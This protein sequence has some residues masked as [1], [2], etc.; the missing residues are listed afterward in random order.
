MIEIHDN[1]GPGAQ[2]ETTLP[3]DPGADME[4]RLMAKPTTESHTDRAPHTTNG[5]T[6]RAPRSLSGQGLTYKLST[7]IEGLKRDLVHTSGNRA[8]KTLAKA[9][10]L[11]V[12]LITLGAG[13]SLD[14]HAIAGG[15][16]LHVLQGRLNVHPEGVTQLLEAGDLIILADNLRKPV[17]ALEDST[18]LAVVA[19]PDGAGAWDG[20]AANG[21]L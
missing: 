7:E 20:E 14:P 18:L 1:P 4:S 8:A 3:A 15:A 5:S 16:A 13:A 2:T 17:E 9:H 21:H 6:S 10:N 12:T 19:W 11:R